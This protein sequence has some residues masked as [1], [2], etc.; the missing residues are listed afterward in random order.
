MV[1]IWK[2]NIK[3]KYSM[4]SNLLCSSKQAIEV[5]CVHIISITWYGNIELAVRTDGQ[6]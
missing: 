2:W 5:L 6:K 3:D 1:I 4:P